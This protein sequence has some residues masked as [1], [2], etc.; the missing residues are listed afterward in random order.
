M[1]TIS[2]ILP[3]YNVEKYLRECFYSIFY[4]IDNGCEII[5][6]DD[7][8]TDSSAS[9]VDEL[10]MN[11]NVKV[12]H[13][14]N[15]GLASARNA[16]LEIAEGKYVAF[17]DSDDRIAKKSISGLMRLIQGNEDIDLVFMQAIKFY[18]DGTISAL[19]DCIDSSG[20]KGKTKEEVIKYISKRP[21]FPGSS[22]TKVYLKS[23]LLKNN[24]RFPG[25]NRQSED[26]GFV[27]DCILLANRYEA[28]DISYYEY[29]QGRLGSIT[30]ASSIRSVNGLMKFIDETILLCSRTQSKSIK[31]SILRFAAYEYGV[32]LFNF[33]SLTKVE[34]KKTKRL[35]TKKKWVL[36]YS[37]SLRGKILYILTSIMGVELA[38]KCVKQVYLK[39]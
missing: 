33:A 18:E 8:S 24:L 1:K 28:L 7:G 35:L 15:G 10:G 6:I 36:K 16:G 25:D 23:F 9:I 38:S 21:K 26:L 22:C 13:K 37:S 20:I 11:E 17:V 32:C 27:R 19:G 34:Q 4:Q 14:R 3:V 39:R 30:S 12:I 5:L 31:R 29:R 2:F